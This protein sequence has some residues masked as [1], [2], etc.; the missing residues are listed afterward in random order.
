MLK[1][2]RFG[3]PALA[4]YG[5]PLLFAMAPWMATAESVRV[6]GVHMQVIPLSWRG[7]LSQASAE[8]RSRWGEPQ[9]VRS[10]QRQGDPERLVFM[11]QAGVFHQTLSLRSAP[12]SGR[13]EA[14]VAV[15]DLRQAPGRIPALPFPTPDALSIVNV[16]QH[17]DSADAPTTFALTGRLPP[18]DAIARLA[19]AARKTGWQ[20][21]APSRAGA[22]LV[23][24]RGMAR[25]IGVA[26]QTPR[27]SSLL[28]QLEPGS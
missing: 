25:F 15:Q 7:N 6:N 20:V 10:P 13:V 28:I 27:G 18:P 21:T 11:R 5:L 23:A 1:A 14:V 3:T 26:V 12:G 22:V 8:L 4:A 2:P 16:V 17:G 24:G 9:L 19:V